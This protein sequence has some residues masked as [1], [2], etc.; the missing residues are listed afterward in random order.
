MAQLNKYPRV[1]K[2]GYVDSA[3]ATR[4]V[5]D[6]TADI[7]AYASWKSCTKS[8]TP[9]TVDGIFVDDMLKT[10]TTTNQN[11]Y[12][13]FYNAVQ[14]NMPAGK[15][16][17]MMNPGGIVPLPFY[18]WA[19]SIVTFEDFAYEVNATGTTFNAGSAYTSTRQKQ[20]IIIHDYNSSVSASALNQQQ[21]VDTM[22][23]TDAV[24]H[25][26]VTN[27]TLQPWIPANKTVPAHWGGDP[28]NVAPLYWK[29]FVASVNATNYWMASHASSFTS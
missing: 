25:L 17:T 13:A 27:G 5:A 12:K 23:Q 29:N 26:F 16:Y 18:S 11:Y 7:K 3:E 15:G 21:L 19:D 28:Y 14:T 24:G 9:V 1:R 4:A 20:S 22:A 6:Y 2:L 10:N 8:A